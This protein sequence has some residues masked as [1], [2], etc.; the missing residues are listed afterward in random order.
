MKSFVGKGRGRATVVLAGGLLASF[1]AGANEIAPVPHPGT[2]AAATSPA[3]PAGGKEGEAVPL[4]TRWDRA[5][6]RPAWASSF[7]NGFVPANAVDGAV[8]SEWV[9]ADTAGGMFRVDLGARMR[10]AAVAHDLR[11]ESDADPETEIVAFEDTKWTVVSTTTVAASAPGEVIAAPAVVNARYVGLRSAGWKSDG[12]DGNESGWRGERAHLST[13]RA[14]QAGWRPLRD[15]NDLR[16]QDFCIFRHDGFTY[17]ASMMKDHC[18]EGILVGRSRDLAR[19]ESLGIAVSRRTDEDRSMVWAPHVVEVGGVYHMFYTGVTQPVPGGWNQKILVASTENPADPVNWQRNESVR[20]LVDGTTRSWFRPSHEGHV[21]NA[22]GWADCRDPMVFEEGGTW[23][24]LYTGTHNDGGIC[25]IATAPDVLGPWTDRGAVLKVPAGIPESCFLL[26]DP[27]GG[28]VIVFNH[29]GGAPDGG[30][31][32]ARGDSLLPEDGRPP[33]GD[34][35]ILRDSTTPG[36]AGWAFEF[37]PG[38]RPDEL[39]SAY[40]SGYWVNFQ[41]ARFVEETNGWTIGGVPDDANTW[42][43]K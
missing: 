22:D 28:Y 27:A 42:S 14:Y 21:W 32:I 31:K 13:F 16:L 11:L 20:F 5:R 37:L 12:N 40:L 24:M 34:L 35:E 30:I 17:V 4:G 29:A 1:L 25:G 15:G 39:L 38:E 36:L 2:P 7:L 3:Q 41:D 6:G 8:T 26:K 9:C 33:F 18:N 10:L 43:M 19:W 23:Y